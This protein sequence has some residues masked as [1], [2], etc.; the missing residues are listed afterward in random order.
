[1]TASLRASATFAL[2]MPARAATR[3]AQLLRGSGRCRCFGAFD[4]LVD[5]LESNTAYAN[6]H[7]TSGTTPENAF[8]GGEIRGQIHRGD[9]DE[10]HDHDNHE[11]K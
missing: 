1:M 5:A 6:I 3:I 8:P 4:A 11:H 9:L 10:E 2:R 7:T